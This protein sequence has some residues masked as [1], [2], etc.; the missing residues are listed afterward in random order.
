MSCSMITMLQPVSACTWRSSGPR[1]SVSRWATPADGSSSS[2]TRRVGGEHAGQL[3]DAAGAGRQVA[4]GGAGVATEAELLDELV[5]PRGHDALGVGGRGQAQRRGD[6][7]VAAAA[8][9]T[10]ERHRQGLDHVERREQAGLLER[11]GRARARRGRPGASDEMSTPSRSTASRVGLGEAGDQVEQRRLAGAVVADEPDDLAGAHVE[12]DAVDRD[13]AAEAP[14]QAQAP[15]APGRRPAAARR[16][17]RPRPGADAV[18][19]RRARNTAWS[20]SGRSSSSAVGPAEAHLALLEEHGP[21]GDRQRDVDRLLDDHDRHAR[22]D[23]RR[24]PRRA[25]SA[26]TVG[27]RPSD[28]SSMSSTRGR[29]RNAWA[30]ASICCS[31]PDRLPAAWSSAFAQDREAGRAPPRGARP[32]WPRR[33]GTP[34]PPPAGSRRRSARGTRHA[35]RAPWRCRPGRSPRATGRRCARRRTTPRRRDAGSSPVM[36]RST[37][38]FPAPLVPSSATTSP[39][40]TDRSTP[41]STCSGPYAASVPAQRQQTVRRG[42]AGLAAVGA[43]RARR[44]P[45]R[46]AASEACAAAGAHDAVAEPAA[47]LGQPAGHDEQQEQHADAG[48]QQLVLGPDPAEDLDDARRRRSRRASTRCRR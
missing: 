47:D 7:P 40:P 19:R 28:S 31:P 29:P 27:A 22:G 32:P 10:V 11:P 16:G 15:T 3:D 4:G 21:L 44:R 26:T 18:G 41:N 1:C 46:G 34:T 20:T 45:R 25:A 48:E 33:G 9:V 24:A 43:G 8:E 2:R 38:D 5:D 17:S 37:L 13:D 14:A 6:E 12:V 42:G 36:A 23:L 39:S 30:S 35:R